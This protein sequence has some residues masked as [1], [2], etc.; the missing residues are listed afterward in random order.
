M[1]VCVV[2]NICIKSL[3]NFVIMETQPKER[4]QMQMREAFDSISITGESRGNLSISA[5][6]L[7]RT[8]IGANNNALIMFL[9]D[10]TLIARLG[11]KGQRTTATSSR[12][13]DKELV[14]GVIAVHRLLACFRI[15]LIRRRRGRR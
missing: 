1:C 15:I 10:R 7:S 9:L 8:T 12:R 6:A 2:Y 4:M 14:F 13:F 5:F 11:R 3:L